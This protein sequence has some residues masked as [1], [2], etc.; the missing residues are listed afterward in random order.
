L[1]DSESRPRLGVAEHMTENARVFDL[2]LDEEDRT[3]IERATSKSRDLFAS[4]GD[5]GAEYR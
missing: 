1:T 4:I 2:S 3:A 5:C